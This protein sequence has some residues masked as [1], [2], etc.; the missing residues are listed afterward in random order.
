MRSL[1]LS[2]ILL[3]GLVAISASNA[4]VALHRHLHWPAESDW[5]GLERNLAHA[6]EVLSALPGQQVQYVTEGA[7][8]TYDAGAYYRLQYILAP[9]IL[10]RDPTDNRYVLVEFW[11]SREVV[12]LPGLLLV[13]DFG[14]G[15]ALYRRL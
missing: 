14:H 1:S 2:K 15:F 4:V 11:T 9:C 12:P 6:K 7:S 13:E 3:C 10:Q 5:S 8:N